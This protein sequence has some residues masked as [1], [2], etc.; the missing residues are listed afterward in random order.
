VQ[1]IIIFLRQI[2]SAM[3][4][5]KECNI[6]HRD[7]KPANILIKDENHFILA[8]FNAC[9]FMENTKTKKSAN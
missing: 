2:L 3:K 7:I 5:L 9:K 6:Y 1:D 8:D 4:K